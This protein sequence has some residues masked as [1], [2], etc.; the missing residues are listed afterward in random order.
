MP[1]LQKE[2]TSDLRQWSGRTGRV[3]GTCRNS[4]DGSVTVYFIHQEW[5]F[6]A[7]K[8]SWYRQ[9]ILSNN[10]QLENNIG[11]NCWDA[12][13]CSSARLYLSKISGE[14][15]MLSVWK[16]PYMLCDEEYCCCE[17]DF[18]RKEKC[19]TLPVTHLPNRRHR[20]QPVC[21]YFTCKPTN[22][23]EVKI[24]RY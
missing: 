16:Q 20:H 7:H 13:N 21:F 3:I 2:K 14:I 8:L 9:A 17:K 5:F 10:S 22:I 6:S 24:G 4:A 12:D 11:Y 23:N 1:S 15:K 18:S 19:N